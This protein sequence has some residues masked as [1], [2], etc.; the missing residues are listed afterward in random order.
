MAAAVLFGLHP[1]LALATKDQHLTVVLLRHHPGD[2]ALTAL[3]SA[4]QLDSGDLALLTQAGLRGTVEERSSHASN[5]V[6]WPR[7]KALVV[8]TGVLEQEASLP[9]PKH[10]TVAFIQTG[11]SFRQ[12]PMGASTLSRTIRFYHEAGDWHVEV[13]HASGARSGGYISP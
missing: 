6:A 4:S 9:Q 11:Q 3:R 2:S 10:G 12:V 13:Q 1:A 5:S 7:A 8:F